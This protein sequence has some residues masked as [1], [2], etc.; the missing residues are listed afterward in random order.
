MI[1]IRKILSKIKYSKRIKY[2]KRSRSVKNLE[3]DPQGF[4]HVKFNNF[5]FLFFKPKNL[6]M[7][8]F[9]SSTQ[10]RKKHEFVPI[11]RSKNLYR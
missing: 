8:N 3:K 11:K 5:G 6:G 7:L 10:S 4:F 9:N 2:P 1:L